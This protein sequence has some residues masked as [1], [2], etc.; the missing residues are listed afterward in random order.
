MSVTYLEPSSAR[1]APRPY[2]L[3][4]SNCNAP[5]IG[6]LS[7]G[8]P[9]CANYLARQATALKR[10]VPGATFRIDTKGTTDHL[11]ACVSESL[12]ADMAAE[13]DA[14]VIAWGHCGSCTSGVA[15]DAIAFAERGIPSVTLICDVFWNFSEWIAEALG[16]PDMPRIR[17]PYPVAG[18]G[19][20]GQDA[21]A[22]DIAPLI[23]A[24]LGGQ[25]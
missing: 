6:L 14:V 3:A 2:G 16:M 12:C 23:L 19:P 7:N 11:S 21:V 18:I 24:K 25:R 8:F 4:L 10:L 9:D 20:Q 5:A 13:C 1:R 15:R 22:S 17:I